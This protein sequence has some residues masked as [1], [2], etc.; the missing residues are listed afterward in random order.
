MGQLFKVDDLKGKLTDYFSG[1]AT[2][3]EI[4]NDL[5]DIARARVAVGSV[6]DAVDMLARLT[7]RNDREIGAALSVLWQTTPE[8]AARFVDGTTPIAERL[9][10]L[11][12]DLDPT[13]VAAAGKVEDALGAAKD[14]GWATASSSLHQVVKA[15]FI[16]RFYFNPD[17]ASTVVKGDFILTNTNRLGAANGRFS[18]YPLLRGDKEKW[19]IALNQGAQGAAVLGGVVQIVSYAEFQGKLIVSNRA[20]VGPAAW[21]AAAITFTVTVGGGGLAAPVAITIT[22]D[23]LD[24]FTEVMIPGGAAVTIDVAV[25]APGNTVNVAYNADVIELDFDFSGVTSGPIPVYRY[26]ASTNVPPFLRQRMD[27]VS[28]ALV[29]IDANWARYSTGVPPARAL[30]AAF[31]AN[32]LGNMVLSGAV[33]PNLM[34]TDYDTQAAAPANYTPAMRALILSPRS[35]FSVLGSPAAYRAWYAWYGETGWVAELLAR[36]NDHTA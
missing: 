30:V 9:V 14:A 15:A 5:S 19:R 17:A 3:S 32:G 16:D 28:D 7:G 1:D 10:V 22:R 33:T 23:D 18:W 29:A 8:R 26:V 24:G 21:T 20:L 35:Y 11:K 13:V 4:N 27:Y 25:A 34:A 31:I 36:R 12:G 2:L 6:S